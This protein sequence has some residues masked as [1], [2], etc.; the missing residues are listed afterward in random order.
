MGP[1]GRAGPR[2]GTGSTGPGGRDGTDG[3]VGATGPQG[4]PGPINK[5]IKN[6][7]Q[8]E[9]GRCS[10]LCIDTY[11]SYYCSCRPGY[12]LENPSLLQTCPGKHST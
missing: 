10:Q 8:T 1:T 5:C 11:S 4:A 7:C 2:G 3:R 6:E 12:K 9:N